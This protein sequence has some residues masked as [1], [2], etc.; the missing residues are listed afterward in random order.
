MP[1]FSLLPEYPASIFEILSLDFSTH[2][3][4]HPLQKHIGVYIVLAPLAGLSFKEVSAGLTL[5][6]RNHKGLCPSM[7]RILRRKFVKLILM[8]VEHENGSGQ[9]AGLLKARLKNLS[10]PFSNSANLHHDP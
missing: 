8:Q 5:R 4:S 7:F 9:K 2:R 1:T 3:S 6:G 10:R